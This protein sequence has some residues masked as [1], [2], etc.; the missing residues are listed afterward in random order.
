MALILTGCGVTQ[1]VT[2]GTKSALNSVFYKKL[3]SCIWISPRAK[4]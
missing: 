2:D 4:L 3:K 1:S